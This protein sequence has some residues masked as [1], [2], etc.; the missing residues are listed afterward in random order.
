MKTGSHILIVEDNETFRELVQEVFTD[1][2]YRVSEAGNG[3][4]ALAVMERASIDLAIVDLE[5]PVMN[6]LEFTARAK[7]KNPKFP[8][9]M[10]TAYA[11][12]HSPAEI[13]AA[14]VDAFLQKPVPMDKL[15]K[16][17]EQM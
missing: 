1:H 7:E 4:E 13:L 12:F 14:N 9:I 5:M 10:V 2:G 3:L 11:A 15:V 16:I 17:V 8:I 6:G